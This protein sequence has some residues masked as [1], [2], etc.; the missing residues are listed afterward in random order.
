MSHDQS[1][2]RA[3]HWEKTR[4]LTIVILILWFIFS[5]VVHWFADSLNALSFLGFPLGYYMAVQGS[6]AV[7]VI[8]IFVHNKLQDG[9]DDEAG[10]SE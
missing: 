1:S 3:V 7:F 8:L 4:N 10:L 6:L 9:I 5:F 2:A